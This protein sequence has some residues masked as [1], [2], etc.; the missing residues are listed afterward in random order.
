MKRVISIY[1][2]RFDDN[3]PDRGIMSD[4]F[5]DGVLVCQV[6]EPPR[7]SK[8]GC[9]EAGEYSLVY[10]YSPSFRKKM[11]Y[12][13]MEKSGSPR[14]GIMFHV[15]NSREDTKGCLCPG[16]LSISGSFVLTGSRIALNILECNIACFGVSNVVVKIFDE[17]EK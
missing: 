8:Y 13:D 4:L 1:R 6:I 11:Y 16:Y 7:L 14:T 9:V 12:L 3:H 5:I 15:G 17:Y 2:N 10:Q